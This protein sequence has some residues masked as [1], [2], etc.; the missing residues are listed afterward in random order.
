MD[1]RIRM[2]EIPTSIPDFETQVHRFMKP[3][4]R[5]HCGFLLSEIQRLLQRGVVRM[6]HPEYTDNEVKIA[7]VRMNLGDDL[8]LKAYP[9]HS[10]I[11]TQ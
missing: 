8:F 3:E 9:P 2:T 5:L 4:E 10:H 1:I 11:S 6:K 7:V